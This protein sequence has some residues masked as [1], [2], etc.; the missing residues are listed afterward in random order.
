M[1]LFPEV[2]NRAQEE[3]ARVVGDRLPTPE[4]QANLPY[5]NAMINE[6]LRWKP[7]V[8]TGL[9]YAATEDDVYNGYTI[10]KG[11]SVLT[12]IW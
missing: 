2:Q 1:V 9:V 12:N 11:A 4:D 10:P 5:V 8:P 7:V 3:I 6:V